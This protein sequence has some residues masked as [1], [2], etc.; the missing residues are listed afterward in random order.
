MA[1]RVSKQQKAE[2]LRQ[3]LVFSAR[4]AGGV[5]VVVVLAFGVRWVMERLH[6]PRTLPIRS[7]Q[8]EGSFRHLSAVQL[9]H[10]IAGHAVGGFFSIDI[11]AIH[12]LL[13][14]QA[15]VNTVA[16]RRIWPDTLRIRVT[17][18]VPVLRWDAH[19][20][21]NVHGQWFDAPQGKSTAQLPEL[22][23]PDRLRGAMLDRYGKFNQALKKLGVHVAELRVTDR[24]AWRVTLSNGVELRLG[25]GNVE[26]RLARFVRVYPTVK[27]QRPQRIAA[28]DL[29]YTNGLA[30]RWQPDLPATKPSVTGG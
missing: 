13:M 2:E 10:V 23:G 5:V 15:W 12:A 17:E 9:Q 27:A 14:R 21:I 29:R 24:R 19:G 28:V 20:F 3:W 16:V 26:R 18:Q 6:D 8:I 4:L 11:G 30:V 1:K 25:R 7:V 22:S